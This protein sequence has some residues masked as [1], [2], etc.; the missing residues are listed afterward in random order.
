MSKIVPFRKS[1]ANLLASLSESER[2]EPN[3]VEGLAS[4]RSSGGV[5]ALKRGLLSL[6]VDVFLMME[7]VV[8]DCGAKAVEVPAAASRQEMSKGRRAIVVDDKIMQYV[9]IQSIES[10]RYGIRAIFPR[11][12]MLDALMLQNCTE[13]VLVALWYHLPNN[14]S[15]TVRHLLATAAR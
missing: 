10:T 4:E 14:R 9:W 12:C 7:V 8:V 2:G 13:S 6:G 3:F 11:H 5:I 15:I 1:M